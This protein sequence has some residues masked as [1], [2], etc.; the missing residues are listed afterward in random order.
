MAENSFFGG[1]FGNDCGCGGS[2]LL[3]FFIILVIIYCCFCGGG[4]GIF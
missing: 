4:F 3:F 2:G 1:L